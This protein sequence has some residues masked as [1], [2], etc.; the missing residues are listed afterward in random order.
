[1]SIVYSDIISL[2]FISIV[3]A[4]PLCQSPGIVQRIQ[5]HFPLRVY[6]FSARNGAKSCVFNIKWYCIGEMLLI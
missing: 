5:G 3:S 2:N 6:G 4:F 1:M